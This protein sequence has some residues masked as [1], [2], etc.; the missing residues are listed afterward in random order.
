MATDKEEI[1]ALRR[2]LDE[3]KGKVS[4][5]KSTFVPM[6]DAE[7]RD[8]VHQMRERQAN[9]WMHP[10]TIREMAGHPCNQVMPG[11]IQD[12]HAPTS[13][14]MVTNSQQ[15]SG[16]GGAVPVNKSGWRDATPIGPPPGIRYVDAQLDA[17]DAR[18]RIELAQRI[19][20]HEAAMRAAQ[21][22][23]G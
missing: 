8:M 10:N 7:H 13:P 14:G 18:D 11:V 12:R 5:P 15:P 1:A 19:A 16:A 3:L 23:K 6:T 2:E 22:G 20:A 21:K 9:S 17:A 4:P